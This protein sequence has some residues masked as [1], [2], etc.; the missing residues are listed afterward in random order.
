MKKQRNRQK[1]LQ[2]TTFNLKNRKGEIIKGNLE[3]LNDVVCGSIVENC[4]GEIGVV[5]FF[6][7]GPTTLGSTDIVC[8]GRIC[9]TYPKHESYLHYRIDGVSSHSDGDDIKDVLLIGNGEEVKTNSDGVKIL[10]E[11]MNS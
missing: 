6:M 9:I 3:N 7:E 4:N 8:G 1:Q 11:F 2:Q 10:K 5:R